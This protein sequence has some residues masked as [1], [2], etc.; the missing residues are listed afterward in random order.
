MIEYMAELSA[1][2]VLI[3]T[4]Q[5]LLSR[6]VLLIMSA[7]WDC[8]AVTVGSGEAALEFLTNDHANLVISDV[9]LPGTDGVQLAERIKSLPDGHNAPVFLM[10]PFEEPRGH[11]ADAFLPSPI[12]PEE[13]VHQATRHLGAP[14]IYEP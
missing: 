13:L 5:P 9:R 14:R 11:Q 4:D 2:V 1:L 3:V 8:S 7:A 6:T 12:D 10:S